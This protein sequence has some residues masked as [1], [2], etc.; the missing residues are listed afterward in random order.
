MNEFL[1]WRRHHLV[2]L[3]FHE[4]TSLHPASFQRNDFSTCST[5]FQLWVAPI[6]MRCE[7]IAN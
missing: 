7:D 2:P 1:F 3:I 6:K 4:V 5:Y